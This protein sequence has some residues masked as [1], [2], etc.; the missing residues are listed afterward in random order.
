[1]ISDI[2]Y[3]LWMSKPFMTAIFTIVF[4]ILIRAWT[5]SKTNNKA[6]KCTKK[7]GTIVNKTCKTAKSFCDTALD[8]KDNFISSDDSD[9]SADESNN[10]NTIYLDTL[11]YGELFVSA[12]AA[13]AIISLVW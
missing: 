1:M 8:L 3:F 13:G 12:A 11:F 6:K 4:L 9:E 5:R 7:I 10:D 2:A